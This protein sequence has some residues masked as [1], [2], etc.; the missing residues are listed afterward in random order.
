MNLDVAAESRTISTNDGVNLHYF[1]A[2][3]GQPLVMIPGWSQTAQQFKHQIE[4]FKENYRVIAIDMR[5]HGESDK[6]EHGYR[7]PRLAKDVHDV[8][9]ALDLQEVILLG[10]SVGCSIIWSYWELF[11]AARLQ[12]LILVDQMSFIFANPSWSDEERQN[13]GAILDAEALFGTVNALAGPEGEALTHGLVSGMM[14]PQISEEAKAWILAQNFKMPRQH[15][16][17]LLYSHATQDWRD[18]LPRI[19]LPTLVIG[20]R[21]SFIPWQSVAWVAS[22]IDGAQLEIFEADERGQHFM[23]TENAEKFNKLVGEFIK[24]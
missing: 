7:L 20:G 1:E 16:A 13:A 3:E 12:K 17:K 9:T 2:G 8:L 22:Q 19:N 23:F 15:A 14:S 11:G 18:V 6:P 4:H 5:G 24:S 10:H 21:I